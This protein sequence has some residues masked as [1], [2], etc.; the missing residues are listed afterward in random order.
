MPM[1]STVSRFPIKQRMAWEHSYSP[2][3]A[4][5]SDF[6]RHM[7]TEPRRATLWVR[8][9]PEERTVIQMWR[10]SGRNTKSLCRYREAMLESEL[11]AAVVLQ[12]L[13]A[14][15]FRLLKAGFEDPPKGKPC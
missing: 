12:Q 8:I 7:M 5:A 6:V 3:W 14:L 10:S 9:H 11:Q 2:K 1:F 4:D 15:G 13:L